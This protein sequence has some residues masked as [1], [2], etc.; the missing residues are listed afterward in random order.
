[1]G[2][3][4]QFLAP[5]MQHCQHADASPKVLGIGGQFQQGLRGATEQQVV[6]PLRVADRQGIELF[7]QSEDDVEV[8]NRQQFGT[9][10]LEPFFLLQALTFRAVTVAARVVGDLACAA[11]VTLVGVT[12]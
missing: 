7:R 4:G 9:T 11:M 2:V 8:R 10:L 5:G 1:M 6:Q 12:A 3:Q